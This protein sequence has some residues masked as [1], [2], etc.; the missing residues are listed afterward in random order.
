MTY[1]E[2]VQAIGQLSLQDRLAILEVIA[3]S[4]RLELA[5]LSDHSPLSAQLYG[6]LRNSGHLPGDKEFSDDYTSFLLR[7]Y[8]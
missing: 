1:Q 6:I 7:K 3:R 8:A 5:A 4:I 2:I